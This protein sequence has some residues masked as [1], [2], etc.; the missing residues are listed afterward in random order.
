MPDEVLTVYD[1]A[2]Q[3]D[4]RAMVDGEEFRHYGFQVRVR[5]GDHPTGWVKAFAVRYYL[6]EGLYDWE[7]T[8]DGALYRVWCA[9]GN[10]IIVL[11]KDT[12]TSKRSLFTINAVA[13]IER[14]V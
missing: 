5:S 13:P 12:P 4:G 6:A 14:L 8:I 1:T 9:N 3:D 7:I 11:G 10:D 2:W